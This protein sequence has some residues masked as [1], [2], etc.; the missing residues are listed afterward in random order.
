MER[1]EL[2]RML[3]LAGKEKPASRAPPMLKGSAQAKRAAPASATAL[4]LDSWAL[5]RGREVLEGSPFLQ[6]LGMGCE[7]VADFHA[8]AFLP[9]PVLLDSC[10]DPVRREFLAQMLGTPEYRALHTSTALKEDASEIAAAAF[11]EQFAS[12]AREAEGKDDG[13]GKAGGKGEGDATDGMAAEMAAMRAAGKAL[14]RASEE[15]EA[16]R[17]AAVALGIGPGSPGSNDPRAVAEMFRRVRNDPALRRICEMAG[18]FRRV[19]QSRQRRKTSHGVDEIVGVEVGGDLGKLLP[20]E[21]ARL[22]LP[23]LELDT[24]RR[25][26]ERHCMQRETRGVERV[27]KGPVIVTVDESGS[28]L[29]QKA[30]AAKALALAVAWIARKQKR[31]CALVAYSGGSGERLLALPPGRWDEVA[32][33]DWLCAFIGRGS[34]I[35]VPV[36]EMP[37]IY[38]ELEAPAGRTDVLFLTDAQCLLPPESRNRFLDWKRQ[39]KARLVTLVI[40][41]TPGDLA[42]ISD[43]CHCVD[44]LAASEEAVGRALSF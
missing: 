20:V 1:D 35:D 41:G 34:D 43:E 32:V 24:L 44:A 7:A 23:E 11:A 26:A 22:A 39:A 4:E 3:D 27:G 6:G 9:D 42:A 38:E 2:L 19:A 25:L 21:L 40:Q 15:V 16:M 31:W 14:A 29:G 17:E 37:R 28:M 30:H 33:M 5:R 36:R 10:M 12:L 13:E 8:A 18:R